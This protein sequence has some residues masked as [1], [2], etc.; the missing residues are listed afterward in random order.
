MRKCLFCEESA[1][2]AFVARKGIGRED[3]GSYE[4]A[5]FAEADL[6]PSERRSSRKRLMQSWT[7][8]LPGTIVTELCRDN[9]VVLPERPSN[10]QLR[11][12]C[13]VGSGPIASERRSGR[14]A[15]TWRMPDGDV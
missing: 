10:V 11:Q 15:S 4:N 6:Q 1:C 3:R 13:L 5:L 14:I 12:R 7:L 9:C 2:L 8:R